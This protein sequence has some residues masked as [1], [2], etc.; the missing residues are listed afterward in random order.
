MLHI[1]NIQFNPYIYE[2][3]RDWTLLLYELNAPSAV[4]PLPNA[5]LMSFIRVFDNTTQCQNHIM[6]NLEKM[7]TLFGHD[8]N[9][10]LWLA[11]NTEI[12]NNLKYMNIFCNSDDYF[13]VTHWIQ[14]YKERLENTVFNIIIF[15]KLNHELLS[16]GVK[17]LRKL[18]KQFKNDFGVL[19]L[20][21]QD[22]RR[23][24]QTLGNRA[25]QRANI[26]YQRIRKSEEAQ[27]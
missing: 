20:L 14:N 8:E 7:I 17:Y 10:Q 6:N 26:E 23:I 16:F 15:E 19:N 18:R 11:S 3:A 27:N 21:D 5:D 4:I 2:H 22:Y 9:M 13:F 24:C 12:S 25:S 1:G